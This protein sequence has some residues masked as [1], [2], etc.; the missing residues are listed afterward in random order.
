MKN[1]LAEAT[2]HYRRKWEGFTTVGATTWRTNATEDVK[3]LLIL[4][5]IDAVKERE[6]R[7]TAA[8]QEAAGNGDLVNDMLQCAERFRKRRLATLRELF[9]AMV[10]AAR[11]AMETALLSD[12]EAGTGLDKDE[13]RWVARVLTGGE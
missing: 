8:N 11:L 5:Q 9:V 7:E 6:Y 4:V 10:A 1:A 12:D 3:E 2:D 13:L